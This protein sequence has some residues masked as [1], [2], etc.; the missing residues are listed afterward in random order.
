M[1]DASVDVRGW[2][3]FRGERVTVSGLPGAGR[4][5]QV[6][7]LEA[8]GVLRIDL[9][10]V[11]RPFVDLPDSLMVLYGLDVA[12]RPRREWRRYVSPVEIEAPE[13]VTTEARV[14]GAWHPVGRID[15]DSWRVFGTD[16]EGIRLDAIEAYRYTSSTVDL[17]S[18]P[19]VRTRKA[20]L[21]ARGL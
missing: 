15:A 16:R 19:R 9:A 20:Y 2:A 12:P 6:G 11:V 1:Q 8:D 3:T 7:P 21:E 5:E 13:S 14:D 18:A 4:P 17:E 10:A